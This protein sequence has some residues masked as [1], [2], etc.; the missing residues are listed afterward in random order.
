MPYFKLCVNAYFFCIHILINY[1]KSFFNLL[2]VL[3]KF[4]NNLTYFI[5]TIGKNPT[6][7]KHCNDAQQYF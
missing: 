3:F 6:S 2:L 1:L 5:E 4:R 7:N